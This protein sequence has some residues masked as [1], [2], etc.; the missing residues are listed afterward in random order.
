[1]APRNDGLRYRLL[2]RSNTSGGASTLDMAEAAV[3]VT[4]QSIHSPHSHILW[5]PK[6]SSAP[7]GFGYDKVR[8]CA[9]P[10]HATYVF[11]RTGG[12]CRL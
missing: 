5:Q 1:M 2:L 10:L 7:V 12:R 8:L 4:W 6:F 3:S 9:K 11:S